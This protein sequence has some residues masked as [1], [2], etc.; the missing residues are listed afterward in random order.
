MLKISRLTSNPSA[1][2]LVKLW[3][4][5]YIPDLST[6]SSAEGSF[7]IAELVK[8]SS[9]GGRTKTATEVKRLIQIHCERAGLKTNALFAYIP[10]I[11]NLAE[12]RRLAEFGAKVYRE[13]IDVYLQQSPSAAS[14]AAMPLAVTQGSLGGDIDLS[15]NAFAEWAKQALELPAIEQLYTLLEPSLL[16]LQE[17]HL[18]SKDPRTIGFINTQFHFSAELILKKLTLPEQVLVSPYLRFVE[19]QA[20][21]PWRRVCSAAAEHAPSSPILAVVE[22]M[23]PVSHE[24]A[25]SVYRRCISLFPNHRSRRGGLKDLGVTTSTVRDL[26]MFQSYL[27]LCVLEGSMAAVEQEL[28]PLC[29]MVFPSVE[30]KWELVAEMT[31]LLMNEIVARLEPVQKEH[32]LPYTQAMQQIFANL[33][34]KADEFNK[35][36]H[37]FVA[38]SKGLN[39]LIV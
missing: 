38:H 12:A 1:E 10:N 36:M 21:I 37:K 27:W 13:A 26:N 4:K 35:G 20:C 32:V 6:L 14:L 9:R 34:T 19:E 23:L 3:G 31:K 15:S 25:M 16:E 29:V 22:Q 18:I 5:R 24:I 7:S 39:S 2:R 33:E 30:V 17:Q 28:V 11:V 8:A